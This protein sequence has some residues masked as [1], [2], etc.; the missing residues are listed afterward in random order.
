MKLDFEQLKH[1]S[2]A[3]HAQFTADGDT[4]Q[5]L[6][7]GSMV[8]SIDFD[9]G[10]GRASAHVQ[11]P[12]FRNLVA[13]EADHPATYSVVRQTS[14]T[15]PWIHWSCTVQGIEIRA[16]MCRDDILKELKS[17]ELPAEYEIC[18]DYDIEALLVLW[19]NMTGWNMP[20]P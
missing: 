1:L 7:K 12:Y 9:P 14:K 10:V 17:L 13:N 19:M 16:C 18:K 20:C 15:K 3:F 2:D 6:G 11:W 8:Y 5:Q 4:S